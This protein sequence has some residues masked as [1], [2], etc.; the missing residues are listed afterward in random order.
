MTASASTTIPLSGG[1]FGK[2]FITFRRV[3][4]IFA[5]D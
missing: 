5:F 4:K 1:V 3:I 2:A